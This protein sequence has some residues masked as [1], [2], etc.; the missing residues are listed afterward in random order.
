VISTNNNKSSSLNVQ[1]CVQI[2]GTV[3]LNLQTQPQQGNS[4]F[5]IIS[6]SCSQ[7]ANV[8]NSQI[9]IQPNYNGSNCDSINSQTIN[10]Q[11]SASVVLSSQ[12]GN[13]CGGTN[14]GLIIGLAVGIPIA[15]ILVV[16]LLIAILKQ[17]QN[18]TM[19]QA[20]DKIEKKRS[21]KHQIFQE[22]PNFKGNN[23][24]NWTNNKDVEM[25]DQI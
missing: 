1:G 20:K 8:T 14:K 7:V 25:E 23:G 9:Q 3:S 2:N 24:P 5:Q 17:R 18:Q 10:N 6:Y 4:T 11:N 15:L 12:L 22:N 21:E 19:K 16:I 13:K